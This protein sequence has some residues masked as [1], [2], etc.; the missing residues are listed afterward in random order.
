MTVAAIPSMTRRRLSL[1]NGIVA[2][3]IGATAAMVTHTLSRQRD[4]AIRES[5]KLNQSL[6]RLLELLEQESHRLDVARR[7]GPVA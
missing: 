5:H 6:E 1:R 3:L 4:A 2:V 7:R